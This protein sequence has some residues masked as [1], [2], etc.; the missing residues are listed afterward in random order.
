[1]YKARS[2]LLVHLNLLCYSVCF[3]ADDYQGLSSL[4]DHY[5]ERSRCLNDFRDLYGGVLHLPY[6]TFIMENM[7]MRVIPRRNKTYLLRFRNATRTFQAHNSTFQGHFYSW[8]NNVSH[9]YLHRKQSNFHQWRAVGN[10][11][12]PYLKRSYN[13]TYP[14]K[15]SEKHSSLYLKKTHN[16][17][18]WKTYNTTNYVRL[19]ST[20]YKFRRLDRSHPSRPSN[21]TRLYSLF[22]NK[23]DQLVSPSMKG[24]DSNSLVNRRQRNSYR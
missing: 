11:S 8:K 20:S 17:N 24:G 6:A 10:G 23:Q 3:H 22:H 7:A 1:M 2:C 9:S 12:Q 13:M 19:N 18:L 14:L 5:I 15:Q 4:P 16:S 21:A